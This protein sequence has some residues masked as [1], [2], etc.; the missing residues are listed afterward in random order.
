MSGMACTGSENQI[1]IVSIDEGSC[2]CS[3]CLPCT[4]HVLYNC[5]FV[6]L[7][8]AGSQVINSAGSCPNMPYIGDFLSPS[9]STIKQND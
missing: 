8:L 1:K 9:S 7:T 4:M 3:V 5:M 6:S 2:S